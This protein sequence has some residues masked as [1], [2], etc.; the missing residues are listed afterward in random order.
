MIPLNEYP[1][2]NIE[3]FNLDYILKTI[4]TL[5]DDYDTLTQF[6]ADLN[7]WKAGIDANVARCLRELA[8][9]DS[10]FDALV[11]QV[12]NRMDALVR[13]VNNQTT[14]IRNDLEHEIDTRL[15]QIDLAITALTQEIANR[16]SL[17]TTQ[18]FA[19][20]ESNNQLNREYIDAK[21]QEFIDS[22]PEYTSDNIF[23]YNPVTGETDT[24]NKTLYDIYE[25]TRD[26]ALTAQEYD[27]LGLTASE[28]DALDL[29]AFE[30]DNYAKLRMGIG[31]YYI[32]SP[33]DGTLISIESAI[34]QLAA[35]HMNAL[36]ASEYDAKDLD[37]DAY[38]ALDLT[39]HD[40]DWN[41]A[42]LVP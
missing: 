11:R 31:F 5:R 20:I 33:F 30:Y 15:N 19:A 40:Y 13:Q 37:A 21:L 38:D 1:Y 12:N 35:L 39:A 3:D 8:A 26:Y 24:L 22:L 28:Y 27:A 41:G 32:R 25:V 4:K 17:L 16:I 23:V 7:S 6:F 14:A 34:N 36:T 42:Q 2:R 10:R 18:L 29:T 9:Y